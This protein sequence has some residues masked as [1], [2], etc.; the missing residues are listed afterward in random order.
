[1]ARYIDR[2]RLEEM[3]RSTL[4]LALLAGYYY[5][6]LRTE[7]KTART[8]AGYEE[9]LG[10]FIRWHDASV[11]ELTL[12]RARSFV[13]ELQATE[14]WRSDPRMPKTGAKLAPMTVANHVRAMKAFASWLDREGYTNGNVLARLVLPRVPLKVIE[15]LT[16][17]EIGRLFGSINRKDDLAL[18][19]LAIL[20]LFLDTGLRLSE[21][22]SL[23]LVDIHFEDQWL[24]VMGKGQ[25][26]RVIPFGAR[27]AQVLTRYLHQGRFDPL[28]RTEAFLSVHGEPINGNV[29]K[30]L[31]ARLRQRSGIKRLHPHLLR[32]TFATSYLVAGGDV[33]TLQSIL[34]HTTLEM[35]RRYVSLASTQVSI[36]HRRFS[37]MDQ[38]SLPVLSSSRRAAV[39]RTRPLQASRRPKHTARLPGGPR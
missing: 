16:E 13:A 10:R 18:R 24:K 39:P 28:K 2:G 9:K 12:D 30:M 29:I 35:T 5:T 6:A 19:D 26:E 4:P 7:G 34:G 21:L 27:A 31:F 37:P 38:L 8:V 22:L 15:V 11:G 36:Q 23:K 1:M 33:F 25:K 17:E 14:K 20:V 32:H 3:G